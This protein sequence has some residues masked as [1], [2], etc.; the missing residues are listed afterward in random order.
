MTGSV[1][2][3]TSS[4]STPKSLYTPCPSVPSLFPLSTPAPTLEWPRALV[5]L[6]RVSMA[7]PN[8]FR[9]RALLWPCVQRG[10]VCPVQQGKA[11]VAERRQFS[12]F[13]SRLLGSAKLR[14]EVGCSRSMYK[15]SVCYGEALRPTLLDST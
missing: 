4:S 6:S 15:P 13:A 2:P 1:E 7:T 12:G 8:T 3:V 14:K 9:S 5:S 11:A 10:L